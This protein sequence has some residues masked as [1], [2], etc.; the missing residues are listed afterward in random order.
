M[1]INAAE[2]I[3][4]GCEEFWLIIN[5]LCDD[6]SIFLH[7]KTAILQAFKD[8]QL[9][10]LRIPDS[11]GEVPV[12]PDSGGLVPCFCISHNKTALILW[13][14]SRARLM[15]VGRKLIQQ[16]DINRAYAV[17]DESAEFWKKCKIES[18]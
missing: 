15:G 6:N 1:S 9:Y 10:G 16:L 8:N 13:V 5:E 4:V 3:N 11:G 2:L 12:I 17:L 7:S 14:H 18:S